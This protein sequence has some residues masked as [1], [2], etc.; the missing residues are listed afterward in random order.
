MVNVN[1]LLMSVVLVATFAVKAQE[2]PKTEVATQNSE[3]VAEL[4]KLYA[5]VTS[6]ENVD[7]AKDYTNT[8]LEQTEKVFTQ[9]PMYVPAAF[10]FGRASMAGKIAQLESAPKE[11]SKALR[12]TKTRNMYIAGGLSALHFYYNRNEKAVGVGPVILES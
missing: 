10:F 2:A 11:L 5:N 7:K 12:R 3:I 9:Y 4:K 8:A 1:K 6:Q